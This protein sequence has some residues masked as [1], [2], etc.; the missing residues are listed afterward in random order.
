MP[1]LP[2]LFRHAKL[3]L[4]ERVEHGLNGVAD[5]A[6]GGQGDGVAGLPCGF[7]DGFKSGQG[8]CG[9][10]GWFAGPIAFPAPLF[11]AGWR[12]GAAREA[13]RSGH[14]MKAFNINGLAFQN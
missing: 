13:S 5:L 3:A 14:F 7:D 4:V 2:S 11:N 12:V 6:F 10:S 8:H 1:V 9:V